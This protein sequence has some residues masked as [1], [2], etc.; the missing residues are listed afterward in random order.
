MLLQT[1]IFCELLWLLGHPLDLPSLVN[2]ATRY[3]EK[4]ILQT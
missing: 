4:Y 3:L 2:D 1:L